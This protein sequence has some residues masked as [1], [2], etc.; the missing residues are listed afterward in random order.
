MANSDSKY[1]IEK[2]T[3]NGKVHYHLYT[4]DEL[5]GKFSSQKAAFNFIKVN[6]K[7]NQF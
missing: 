4:V 7:M 5:I 6:E 2:A 3:Y 1:T